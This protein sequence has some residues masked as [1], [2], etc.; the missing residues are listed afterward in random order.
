MFG[1]SYRLFQLLGFEVKLDPSWLILAFLIVWTL[2]VGW[3]P[4]Y[5]PDIPA[6]G[7]WLMGL[8]GALGLFLSIV[9]HELAH[10]LV[11]RRNGIAMHGITLFIFGG[12]A[13]MT[14]EPPSAKSEFMMAIA[15]PIASLILSVMFYV[16]NILIGTM[17]WS[18][19]IQAVFSYLSMINVILAAF[20]LIPAFPLDGGRVLRSALWALK[21]DLKW[22]SRISSRIGS[23]F[24]IL[25]IAL[26][27]FSV[28]SGNFIGGIWWFLIGLFLLQASRGSY[29]QFILQKALEGESIERFIQ[30]QPVTVV[31]TL[32]VNDLVEGYFYRYEQKMF[33]VV[34]E[35]ETLLGCVDSNQI[36][37]I[38]KENWNERTVGEIT[39][40]C[41]RD[42]TIAPQ[43]DAVKAL[44]YMKRTGH[45][46]MMVANN[47][48]LL[49]TVSLKDMLRFLSVKL[50][51]DS[52]ELN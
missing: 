18:Q 42:N 28:F 43:T 48:H 16:L 50:D 38:P 47:S 32:S 27:A 46:R 1:K 6:A 40:E 24:G 3:F 2:A 8:A 5:Y 25:L 19:P 22:A 23:A 21:K 4:A 31:S 26:G 37:Q 52:E 11:A 36:K 51:L 29:R 49:G 30:T 10:A 13:E 34:D 44:T 41:S 35:S 7:Y 14:E 17:V 39:I 20:N 15:G 9:F 33:P 45:G 12:V